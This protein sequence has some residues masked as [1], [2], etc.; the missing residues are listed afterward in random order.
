MSRPS[1]LA[2]VLGLVVVHAACAVAAPTEQGTEPRV[3]RGPDSRDSRD[4]PEPDDGADRGSTPIAPP[5]APTETTPAAPPGGAPAGSPPA[6]PRADPSVARPVVL[7]HGISGGSTDFAAMIERLVADGWPRD[8]VVAVQYSDPSWG[9]NVD[10]AAELARVVDELRARTG[11]AEVDIVAHSMGSLSSRHYVKH[12]GG[13]SVVATYV[14]L[15]GMHLGLFTPCL[16]PLPVCVWQELCETGELVGL[17]NAA[18]ATPDGPRWTSIAS[19]G[20]ETVP[21][22]RAWLDG[23]DNVVVD[24]V[25]H[26]GLLEDGAVYA[27]V[28]AALSAP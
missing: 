17:L 18:P 6:S 13:A 25:S 20:D 28:R 16:S 8:H 27:L 5:E 14:S 19:T 2:P 24:G 9:C 21:P 4:D 10:N 3:Q 23:A 11:A 26:E 15:G 1:L 7:V 12:L 22:E